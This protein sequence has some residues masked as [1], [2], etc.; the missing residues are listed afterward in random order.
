MQK[1]QFAR[2]PSIE[3]L[4]IICAITTEKVMLKETKFAAEEAAVI[5]EFADMFSPELLKQVVTPKNH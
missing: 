1:Y 3:E 4:L 5:K 2:I